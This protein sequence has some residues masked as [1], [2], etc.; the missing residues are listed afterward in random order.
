MNQSTYETDPATYEAARQA[1]CERTEA[2][3]REGF[4]GKRVEIECWDAFFWCVD[5]MSNL[6]AIEQALDGAVP[7]AH[8]FAVFRE[9]KC[10]LVAALRDSIVKHILATNA[11]RVSQEWVQS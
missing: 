8:L 11:D 3:L 5:T 4:T 1:Y 9:S 2:H 7:R 10:P 6:L